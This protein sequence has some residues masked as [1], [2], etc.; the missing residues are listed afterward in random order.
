MQESEEEKRASKNV[1]N[2]RE[3]R[4]KKKVIRKKENNTAINY[5]TFI[6]LQLNHRGLHVSY[7]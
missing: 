5:S 2:E 6:G 4:E 7:K 1:K 3:N